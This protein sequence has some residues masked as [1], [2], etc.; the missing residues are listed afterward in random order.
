MISHL[1]GIYLLTSRVLLLPNSTTTEEQWPCDLG[2]K[3]SLERADERDIPGASPPLQQRV[4]TWSLLSGN[5][6]LNLWCWQTWGRKAGDP[7]KATDGPENRS[8]QWDSQESSDW[9][10]ALDMRQVCLSMQFWGFKG[11]EALLFLD[12]ALEFKVSPHTHPTKKERAL[13]N[14]MSKLP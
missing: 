9:Q 7:A 13:S 11:G 4:H 10:L 6:L 14:Q 3:W 2:R 1:V 5:K 12:Q 8:A